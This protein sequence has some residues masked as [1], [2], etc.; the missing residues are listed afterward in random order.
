MIKTF[1]DTNACLELQGKIF[2]FPFVISSKT[3]EE[4]E[5]IKTSDNKDYDIKFKAR[6]LIRLLDL[7]KDKY[8]VMVTNQSILRVIEEFGLLHFRK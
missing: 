7:N 1:Y 2:D 8:E 5:N 4:I 6:K 3:L